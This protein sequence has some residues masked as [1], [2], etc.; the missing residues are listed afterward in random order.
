ML[1]IAAGHVDGIITI[2]MHKEKIYLQKLK[3]I[4]NKKKLEV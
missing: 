1:I 2:W 4:Y 3:K